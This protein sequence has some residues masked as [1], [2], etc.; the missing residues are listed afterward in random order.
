[1]PPKP[2]TTNKR[3]K[4]EELTPPK[5]ADANIE[6]RVRKS[7]REELENEGESIIIDLKNQF[8]RISLSPDDKAKRSVNKTS[9]TAKA[10][11]KSVTPSKRGR[12]RKNSD[13]DYEEEEVKSTRTT[14]NT[15]KKL[16][17]PEPKSPTKSTPDFKK[18]KKGDEEEKPEENTPRRYTT[19][20]ANKPKS[21]IV[22]YNELD[23]LYGFEDDEIEKVIKASQ[24]KSRTPVKTE[25]KPEPAEGT[26]TPKKRGRKPKP[27]PE[28]LP[29]AKETKE[30]RVTP[31]KG[32]K[33][34]EESL[35]EYRSENEL[36][37]RESS[38]SIH[39]E[40]SPMSTEIP[41]A[42]RKAS[43]SSPIRHQDKRM[44]ALLKKFD[45]AILNLQEY[46]LPDKIPCR[47][48]EKDVIRAFIEEGLNNEG[49][50]HCLCKS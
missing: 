18:T 8:D 50:S 47:E 10:D 23:Y 43:Q 39:V 5:T 24:R 45:D 41:D 12:R 46:T 26:P 38:I 33:N 22:K 35:E 4:V 15:P 2:K 44:D 29:E 21:S 14:R 49:L 40:D 11:R 27:K 1:M 9:K 3:R 32:R 7:D 37:F 36:D 17:S 6:K 48:M 19:R 28:A 16:K 25:K 42:K 30:A 31:S 13:S 34:S 20:S